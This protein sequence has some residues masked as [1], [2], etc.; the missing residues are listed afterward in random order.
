M[1]DLMKSSISIIIT[2][3]NEEGN[4]ESV[5]D[6]VVEAVGPRFDEYE[7]LIVNDGS[8]DKT[9]EIAER[10]AEKNPT[11]QATHNLQNMG[12]DYSYRRGIRLASKR[13]IAWIA[14]NDLIRPQ[15]YEDIFDAIGQA[16]IVSTYL[17][18][19]VRGLSR[20]IISRAFPLVMNIL[21]GLKLKYY[22]GPC[23]YKSEII[24][25]VKV[26]TQ[27]SA[28]VAEILLR[29]IKAGHSYVAVGLHPL[30]RT[31]GRTK[32]FRLKNFVYIGQAMTKLFWDVR[33]VGIFTKNRVST[34]RRLG[35]DKALS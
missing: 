15:G 33:I 16:D 18:T 17:S 22:T 5:V 8:G 23:V 31:S 29:S 21:F 26:T 13:Y 27:G 1:G 4:L 20:R 10:L 3:M 2:A 25:H 9:G 6:K 14:G 32:S 11:I 34:E 35:S 7:I 12:L 19:D 30:K 24:K 28:A